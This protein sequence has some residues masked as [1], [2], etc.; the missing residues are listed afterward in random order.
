MDIN[1]LSKELLNNHE[2]TELIEAINL[3]KNNDFNELFNN[4][5]NVISETVFTKSYE[6]FMDFIQENTFEINI[7][8]LEFLTIKN[9][10][11]GIGGYEN[12]IGS[13]IKQF[14]FKNNPELKDSIN[15]LD[16]NIFTDYDGEDNFYNYIYLLNKILR[17]HN[18]QIIL[19]FNNVYCACAYNLFLLRDTVADGITKEWQ[20]NCIQMILSKK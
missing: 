6:E 20:D 1:L 11:I 10:C 18:L 3:I 16:E 13:K 2:Y 7:F 8:I 19:F 12:N 17:Q 14:I 5:S 15:F 4:Y 9:K